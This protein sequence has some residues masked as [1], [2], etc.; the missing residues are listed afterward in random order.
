[1]A[2]ASIGVL[3]SAF[4]PPHNGHADVVTQA[5]AE[6]DRVLLVPS[7]RHAFGKNML[8]YH[9]RLQMVAALVENM[10]D[11]RVAL[12]DIEES[13]A[14]AQGDPTRP[15]YTYDVLAETERQFPN[16]KIA[17]IVGPDNA[18]TSTWQKFYRGDEI[19]KRWCLWPAAERIPVR[20]SDIRAQAERGIFPSPAQCPPD[21]ARLLRAC[22][23]D[24]SHK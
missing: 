11:E 13:L 9:W 24:P 23:A 5:L 6:F 17:F 15:V 14:E 21:V 18:A 2:A 4:N 8:P 22:L 16:G 7:Y 1:M 10:A 12:F 3:G 19:L 20:S